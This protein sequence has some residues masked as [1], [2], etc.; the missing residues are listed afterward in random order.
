[1][2]MAVNHKQGLCKVKY[3]VIM[4]KESN[5]YKGKVWGGAPFPTSDAP[6]PMQNNIFRIFLVYF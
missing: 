1:M 3:I 4:L 5:S 6:D 2:D